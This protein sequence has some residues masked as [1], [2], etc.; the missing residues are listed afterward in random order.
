MQHFRSHCNFIYIAISFTS[1]QIT[2]KY[3]QP[4][5]TV[6]NHGK[7]IVES[8]QKLMRSTLGNVPQTSHIL[9]AKARSRLS[10]TKLF[11]GL[12]LF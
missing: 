3:N 11:V 6:T 1:N 4:L 7:K 5:F 9:E 8:K 2:P 12:I 10:S